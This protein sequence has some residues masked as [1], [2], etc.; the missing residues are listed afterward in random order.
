MGDPD[1]NLTS[2]LFFWSHPIPSRPV[3]FLALSLLSYHDKRLKG[4]NKLGFTAQHW[5][6]GLWYRFLKESACLVFDSLLFNLNSFVLSG[7]RQDVS[8]RGPIVWSQQKWSDSPSWFGDIES[9]F[10]DNVNVIALCVGPCMSYKS[11]MPKNM[12]GITL[13]SLF[14]MEPHRWG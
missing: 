6:E 13:N 10:N 2:S 12:F 9:I 8:R 7:C 1:S 5:T 3:P 4:T 14:S 11:K